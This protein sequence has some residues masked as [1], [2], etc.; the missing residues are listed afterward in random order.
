MSKNILIFSGG[1]GSIRLQEGIRRHYLKDAKITNLVN[2]YDDGKSTGFVR[3]VFSVLGPSD[4]RKNQY[5]QWKNLGNIDKRIDRLFEQRYSNITK[6]QCEYL[7]KNCCFR[8]DVEEQFLVAITEFFEIVNKHQSLTDE[9]KSHSFNIINIVYA[10]LFSRIGVAQ[11]IRWFKD[12]LGITDDVIVNDISNMWI[13]ATTSGKKTLNTEADIVEFND[14]SDRI[15]NLVFSPYGYHHSSNVIHSC[16]PTL[17]YAAHK[18]I[19]EADIII[20]SSGTQWSSLIPT[21]MTRGIIDALRESKA[22]KYLVLNNT[23]DSDM[24]GVTAKE[25]ISTVEKFLPIK[26]LNIK[27]VANI[28]AD[29]AMKLPTS[30]EKKYSCISGK[31]GNANGKHDADKLV[32]LILSDYYKVKNFTQN[33]ANLMLDFDDTIY[34]RNAEENELN[35]Q[36]SIK[37]GSILK[38]I[39]RN[40]SHHPTQSFRAAIVSGN[41]FERILSKMS[42]IMGTSRDYVEIF[43]DGG[44]VNLDPDGKKFVP[45]NYISRIML[46][47]NDINFLNNVVV[48]VTT[49]TT[50]SFKFEVRG[51]VGTYHSCFSLYRIPDTIRKLIYNYLLEKLDSKR[52]SV[53]LTGRSTI[54]IFRTGYDKEKI[55]DVY[56]PLF[57]P[58]ETLYI[59]D[60][61]QTGNDEK[62]SKKVKHY[63]NVS[64][65]IETNLVLGLILD[66]LIKENKYEQ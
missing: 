55:F 20:F 49:M 65:V 6:E 40:M 29:E 8:I 10:F 17:T 42:A 41:S 35:K 31:I 45:T 38:S 46:T 9:I 63:I 11:T 2:A 51:S 22:E 12:F 57:N 25:F 3:K 48:D 47:Q 15:T 19:L 24:R 28:E 18:A 13:R 5:T 30:L 39:G 50:E 60:E 64:S 1:T 59:G 43:A 58:R 23:P 14:A 56:S 16:V 37:N 27:L 52:Y 32:S 21:Y 54:D 7:I 44:L 26:K 34:A 36:I 53:R 62:I 33:Y 66:E 61:C 4:I